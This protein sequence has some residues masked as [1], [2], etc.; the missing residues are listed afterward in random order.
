MEWSSGVLRIKTRKVVGGLR[1]KDED[2]KIK[3]TIKKLIGR[4][5]DET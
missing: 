1:I 5:R 3:E 4:R 2:E